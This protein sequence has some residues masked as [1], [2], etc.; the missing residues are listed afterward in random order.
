MCFVW[1]YVYILNITYVNFRLKMFQ[2][3]TYILKYKMLL[4]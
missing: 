4:R 2:L 3:H 1:K